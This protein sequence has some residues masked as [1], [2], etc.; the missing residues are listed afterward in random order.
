MKVF[1]EIFFPEMHK[2]K[3]R[4]FLSLYNYYEW[5]RV[6]H[7]PVVKS[8]SLQITDRHFSHSTIIMNDNMC[9]MISEDAYK[10]QTDI[11]ITL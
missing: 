6:Q 1:T 8:R 3:L 9:S 11:P 10:L 5:W 2:V 4:T 7:T